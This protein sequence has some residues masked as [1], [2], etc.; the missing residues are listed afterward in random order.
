[1]FVIYQSSKLQYWL[2]MIN[3]SLKKIISI[4]PFSKL[5]FRLIKV[6]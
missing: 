4:F 1:M 6:I 5:P 2:K 3:F